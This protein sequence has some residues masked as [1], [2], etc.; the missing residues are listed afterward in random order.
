LALAQDAIFFLD[1]LGLQTATLV[2]HDWGASVVY[3]AAALA[4]SRLNALVAIGIPHPK[5][6]KPSGLPQALLW[7]WLVRHVIVHKYTG[8]KAGVLLHDAHKDLER[9]VLA[10]RNWVSPRD[11]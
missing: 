5:F 6:M 4:A 8:L 9:L 1:A 7:L 3:S 10:P 2:G 11:E